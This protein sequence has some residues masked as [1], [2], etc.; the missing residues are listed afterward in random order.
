MKMLIAHCHDPFRA[1]ALVGCLVMMCTLCLVSTLCSAQQVSQS[2]FDNGNVGVGTTV[3]AQKLD[4][5]GG[6]Q[7]Q[8]FQSIN[9]GVSGL[10]KYTHI[11][12]VNLSATGWKGSL[13][14]FG[15]Y[16]DGTNWVAPTDGVNNE[17]S[18]I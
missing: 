7:A 3:P 5:N 4:V 15:W 17:A 1:N 10:G 6:A 9:Q 11:Q 8:V 12:G 2:I 14:S 13:F 16:F 18:A